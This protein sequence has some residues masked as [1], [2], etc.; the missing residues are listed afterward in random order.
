MASAAV[1]TAVEAQL[2]SWSG[3]SAY[4]FVDENDVGNSPD[5]KFLTIEYP[6]ANEDRINV[7]ARPVI[8]RETG[9]IRFVL[10]ILNMSGLAAAVVTIDT[11]RDHFREQTLAGVDT[12]EAAPAA[13]D[14]SN[15]RGSFYEIA[16]VVTYRFDLFR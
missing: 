9:A 8:F 13:Y 16:F 12:F 4:P 6:V 5:D 7:G 3:L 11:L 14:K 15:R 10:H 1:K 2:Q